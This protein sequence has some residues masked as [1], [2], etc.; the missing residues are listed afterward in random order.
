MA[1]SSIHVALEIGT[2]KTCMVVGEI[3]SDAYAAIIGMGVAPSAGIRKGEIA[4]RSM[5]CRCLTD[6][7]QRAQ[8][9]T[10]VDIVNV[11]VSVTGEHIRGENHF[12]SFR[13]PDH[14]KLVEVH[15]M[16]QAKQKAENVEISTDRIVLHTMTGGYRLD[17]REPC[18]YP[19]GLTAKTLDVH[20]HVIHGLRSIIHNTLLCVR[21]VP[22]EVEDVVFAPIAG[23][24]AVLTRQQK[25]AGALFIDI[26]AGTTDY[27]CYAEGDIVASGCIPAGGSTINS[28]IQKMT[29]NQVSLTAAELLKCTEGNAYGDMKDNSLVHYRD[30]LGLRNTHIKRGYLNRI[31]CD[32]LTDTLQRVKTKIPAEVFK[33]PGM[34]VYLA[35]GTSLMRGIQDLAQYIFKVKVNA[36]MAAADGEE[37]AFMRD[38]RYCTAIGMI[39]LAQLDEDKDN[40]N[41]SGGLWKSFLRLFQPKR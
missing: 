5:A 12:G 20:S 35:G 13:L 37:F 14:E 31:I 1:K 41:Q 8:E 9:H 17:G 24:A 11:Y 25:E 15:H 7:W 16:D 34:A 21:E 10:D 19:T 18:R 39:R 6:A 30:E 28:D 23:A 2:H 26:G 3:R 38:P 33:R 27:V 36:P 32:R 29:N 22:L 40:R 4:D